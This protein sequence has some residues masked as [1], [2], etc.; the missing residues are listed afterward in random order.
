MKVRPA[1]SQA[2]AKAGFSDRNPY[3]GCTA[4]APHRRAAPTIA[5]MLRYESA[6]AAPPTR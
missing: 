4:S 6:G 3:P 1:S 5:E 2:S